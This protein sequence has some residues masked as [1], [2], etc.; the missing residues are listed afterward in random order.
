MTIAMRPGGNILSAAIKGATKLM[1][2]T[3]QVAS[4]E[5]VAAIIQV[6]PDRLRAV[7][8]DTCTLLQATAANALMLLQD[9]CVRLASATCSN[10]PMQQFAALAEAFVEWGYHY[11]REFR[12]IGS[13][14]AGVFETDPNL[15]RYES[16][17][18]EVMYRILDRAKQQGT[19]PQDQD[20]AQFIAIAHTYAY[21]VVSKMLLGDLARWNPGMTDREAAHHNLTIFINQFLGRSAQI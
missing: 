11:P 5:D 10:N 3:G 1:D 18:H 14:P 6:C 7:V 20:I 15:M 2:E 13:M 12:I 17:I 4:L 8:P 9:T 21:G 19:L 16:A